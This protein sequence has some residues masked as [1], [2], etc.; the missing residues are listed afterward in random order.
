MGKASVTPKHTCSIALGVRIHSKMAREE[1]DDL[2][3]ISK[4]DPREGGR[5]FLA[6]HLPRGYDVRI[7]NSANAPTFSIV[8]TDVPNGELDVVKLDHSLWHME[9]SNPHRKV[10]SPRKD[11][12]VR[13]FKVPMG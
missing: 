5:R 8:R 2:F 13:V 9:A 4:I 10:R 3:G 7:K 6:I 12:Q 1:F 11:L